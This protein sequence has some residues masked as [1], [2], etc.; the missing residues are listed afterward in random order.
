MEINYAGGE[1][2]L[3]RADQVVAINPTRGTKADIVLHG[4]R[5]NGRK[6]IVDGPGEYEIGGT[7]I[8]TLQVGSGSDTALAHA[9]EIGGVNVVYLGHCP[10][11]LTAEHCDTLGRVDV[12]LVNTANLSAAE[13][14]VRDLAPRVVIPYGPHAAELCAAA[15]VKEARPEARF[16]WNG[17]GKAPK[18]L[19]LR[20]PQKRTIAA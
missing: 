4:R 14:A 15:G 9:V 8:A 6:L 2:F 19:L 16:S 18:A 17:T 3:L 10:E 1:G 5:R 20:S 13:R 7:L 11:R 12:L